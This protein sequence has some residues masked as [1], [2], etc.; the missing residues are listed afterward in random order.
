MT[1]AKLLQAYI[2]KKRAI[3]KTGAPSEVT[4]GKLKPAQTAGTDNAGK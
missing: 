1:V 4:T 3:A 2:D